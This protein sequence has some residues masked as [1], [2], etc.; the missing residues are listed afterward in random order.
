MAFPQRGMYVEQRTVSSV[1]ST[2]SHDT[3]GT[4]MAYLAHNVVPVI[5]AA[6]VIEEV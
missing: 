2:G 6:M 4:G 3:G 1:E 5:L